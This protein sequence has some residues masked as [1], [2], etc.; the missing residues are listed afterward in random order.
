[1]LERILQI[2]LRP[3]RHRTQHGFQHGQGTNTAWTQILSQVLDSPNI[4]EYDLKKYFDS[5]N[6]TYL[7]GILLALGLPGR[8]VHH[9]IL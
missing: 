4:Y 6:L 5:I 2:W 8:L 7:R 9:I 3:Y 1:M